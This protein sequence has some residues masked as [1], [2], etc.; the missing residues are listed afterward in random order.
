MSL[1]EPQGNNNTRPN[2]TIMVVTLGIVVLV[3]IWAILF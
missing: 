2:K 1:Y 3:V